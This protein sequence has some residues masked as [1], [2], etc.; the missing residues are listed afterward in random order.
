MPVLVLGLRG[1]QRKRELLSQDSRR[2]PAG[3]PAAPLEANITA[4]SR[5]AL[6]WLEFA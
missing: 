5:Y 2:R 6:V 1:L 3:D 4:D